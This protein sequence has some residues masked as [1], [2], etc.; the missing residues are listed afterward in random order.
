[1]SLDPLELV[2]EIVVYLVELKPGPSCARATRSL[3][4]SAVSPGPALY[5]YFVFI[6]PPP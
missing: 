3:D 4:C 2:L 6:A 5:V 1:M